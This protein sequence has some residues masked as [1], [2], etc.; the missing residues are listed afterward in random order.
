MKNWIVELTAGGK[1][2]AKV[3]IQRDIFQRDSLSLLL[4]LLAM[5][6]INHIFRK[7][8]GVNKFIEEQEKINHLMYVDDVKL[9]AK[10]EKELV[11]L[12]QAKGIYSQDIGMEFSTEKCAMQITRSR[13]RETMEGIELS[14]QERIKMFIEEE[15]YK[16]LGILEVDTIKQVKMKEKN[17]KNI[18]RKWESYSKINYIAEISSKG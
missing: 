3:E 5:I 8:A 14:N 1:T 12:K 11:T 17:K 9:F 4:F 2:L 15:T 7:C 18:S 6:P 10:S 16:Y 13:K